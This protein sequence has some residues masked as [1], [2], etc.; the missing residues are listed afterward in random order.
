MLAAAGDVE[1][2]FPTYQHMEYYNNPPPELY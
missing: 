1:N 2:H